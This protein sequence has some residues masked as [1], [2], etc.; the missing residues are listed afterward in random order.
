[1]PHQI[2]QNCRRNPT[3]SET[4]LSV[5]LDCTVGASARISLEIGQLEPGRACAARQI[6]AQRRQG[7]LPGGFWIAIYIGGAPCRRPM[8]M[9]LG[10][11]GI[12]KRSDD[13]FEGILEV[14]LDE[15]GLE[16]PDLC[17]KR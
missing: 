10:F 14:I 12:C 17:L 1:M 2:R 6:R 4:P 15:F 13:V 5:G 7:R 3:C 11:L 16:M 9:I 8:G